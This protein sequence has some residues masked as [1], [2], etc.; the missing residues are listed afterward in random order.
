MEGFQSGVM[1]SYEGRLSEKQVQALSEYL[2]GG[3]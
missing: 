1:P 3:Q 2:L